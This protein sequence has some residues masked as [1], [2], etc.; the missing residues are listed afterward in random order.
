MGRT[1]GYD[2]NQ[3]LDNALKVFWDKGYH[4]S[5]LSDLT[6]ATGLHKGSLYSAFKSKEDLFLKALA[7]Y[8]KRTRTKFLQEENPLDYIQSFF[9]RLVDEGSCAQPSKG[10]FILNSNIELGREK[11]KAA[12]LSRA[13]YDE[14]EQNF[15]KAI[16]M[17]DKQG[18]LNKEINKK[19]F[20][21]RTI[22]AIFSIREISRFKNDKKLLQNIANGVLKEIDRKV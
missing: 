19:E 18:E 11:S 5:S 3:V 14:I 8:G 21:A 20:L 16:D 12:K 9:K 2:I 15:K 6:K 17:A 10:C 1:I 22:G 4:N 7:L 13:L